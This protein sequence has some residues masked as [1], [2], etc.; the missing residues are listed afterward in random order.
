MTDDE[1]RAL[2]RTI[3]K[4]ALK[5]FFSPESNDRVLIYALGRIAGIAA[6]ALDKPTAGPE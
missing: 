6:A 1:L 4:L 2:L 5:P 3:Q